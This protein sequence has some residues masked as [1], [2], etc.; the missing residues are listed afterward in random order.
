MSWLFPV[1]TDYG[2]A[3]RGNVEGTVGP[4]TGAA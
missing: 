3:Q 2:V 1:I 4:A